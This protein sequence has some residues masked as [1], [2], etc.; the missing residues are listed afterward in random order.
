[1]W[2]DAQIIISTPQGLEN[3]LI[4]KRI[5]LKE[6]SLLTFDECVAKG[7]KIQLAEGNKVNI[8]DVEEL[9]KEKDLF[10]DS[11][12]EKTGNIEP[13]KVTK[14]H[15]IKS[16][17]NILEISFGN[18]TIKVTSD[19]KCFTDYNGSVK[20]RK[21]KDLKLD[22][23]L[24]TANTKHNPHKKK[25]LISED[26]IL[27][28]YS[29]EQKNLYRHYINV[30]DIRK[31][32]QIGARK[33][34][35]I[36]GI[37]EG[38]IRNWINKPFRSPVSYKVVRELKEKNLLPLFSD[39]SYLPILARLMG[40]LYGDGW[41][42]RD[43]NNN[44]V[45][46]FSGLVKDLKVIQEDLSL[47]GSKYSSISSRETCSQVHHLSG[48]CMEIKGT[49]NSFSATDKK[50]TRILK[51]LGVPEGNKT[52]NVFLVPK[53]IMN[54][55][56]K[57]KKEF[58]S[59][60]MGSEGYSPKLKLNNKTC[61]PVRLSFSIIK[62]H[63]K[64]AQKYALQLKKLFSEFKVKCTISKRRGNTRK[65]GYVTVK[66][67]LTISNSNKDMIN[68][69]KEINYTYA[70]KKRI[71]SNRILNYLISK[72]KNLK[73]RIKL[74]HKARNLHKKGYGSHKIARIIG[75]S[76]GTI[77]N[78]IYDNKR[79][80]MIDHTMASFTE[81]NQSGTSF[82]GWVTIKKI[83]EVKREDYVYDLTVEV[84]HNYFAN[85]CLVH[86]CHH[87][88]G[89]Y[90]YVW[91]AQQYDKLSHNSRILA[92]TASP[93]A[94]LEKI[95]EVCQ[96]LKIE[97]VEVRTET[98]PDVKPY[99]QEV[100]M[101]WIKID[102]PNELKKIQKLL[103]DS[104]KSKLIDAQKFGYANSAS[105]TKTE[106]L[107]L[108]GELQKKISS[109]CRDYEILKSISL[110]AEALK[111]DHALELLE[112]QG[113]KPLNNYFN[114]IRSQALTSKVKA[115]KNLM[116]DLNFKSAMFLIEE[117]SDQ[118]FK[119]PKID[120]LKEIVENTINKDKSSKI[121]IFTQFR[122]SAE[123]VKKE[124]DKIDFSNHIFF[125]QAK[126]NGV[127]FSQK[128]QK[129]ILN[130]FRNN[131]FNVLIA[132][133]VAEEGLD[134]P[135]VDEV[136]FYEPVPSAIRSIQRKGR[137]GRL[138][139]GEVKI[140]TTTGT[141]DEAYRWSAHHK[142]KRMYKNL[143]KIKKQFSLNPELN[144]KDKTLDQFIPKEQSVA[145]LADHREKGNKIVKELIDLGVSVKTEQLESADY[146]VS[147]RVGVELKKVPDFVASIIDGRLLTQ[148]RELKKNFKRAV[149]IIEGEEDIYS[150][151]KVHANAIKGMLA[152]IVL[153]FAVPVLYTKDPR[154]TA[155]LLAVMAKREQDKEGKD[156]SLHQN[157]P[158]SLKEQQEFLVSAMP[159]IGLNSAKLLLNN[160]N[161][162]KSLVNASKED[163]TKIKGVGDKTADKL[164]KLFEEEYK[165]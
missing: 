123:E 133:S 102:F 153:D 32:E 23:K 50:I 33:I 143:E 98:D 136:I 11:L 165:K 138:E 106:L 21:A 9:M 152:A 159:S 100:K 72:D 35:Q 121:I 84:N 37:N 65:D 1:M 163:I 57:V 88:T 43:R 137:T 162:I 93:G 31:R 140:L 85:E 107:K 127:G 104:R 144:Q 16:L 118:N 12:N 145:I 160:F 125:G 92:L 128:Q 38:T 99:M 164:I 148:V 154:D 139:K 54:G 26:N 19:H 18:K 131:E 132:T 146:L 129:E 134:I 81:N 68:F 71:E 52:K 44:L 66:Y 34:H 73:E 158:H 97:K 130:Q 101:N 90:A 29:N 41:C 67:L 51:S 142:E 42:Y 113:V 103:Q 25:L 55:S 79:P 135:K 116:Q 155:Q 89:E 147:G 76:R 45:L 8:E 58:L 109:G 24:A 69:L 126:K 74:Y 120:K 5:D 75:E 59:A 10:V 7:T 27:Q 60:L 40:H 141:R 91:L 28:Q 112:T 108:Q 14:F 30:K 22:T 86:N 87:A 78:W 63:E 82:T 83:K 77:E 13:R 4:N 105:L 36:I 150:I 17:K 124:L 114:R 56:I 53:W 151:R 49:S 110:I 20:W 111:I 94:D 95:K 80:S 39:N 149:L 119:H 46:G 48:K 3:D 115:V 122:D 161:S 15:K 2:K 6:V 64:E 117:L 157:K 62:N 47:L 96:N 70:Y 156:Y 61:N